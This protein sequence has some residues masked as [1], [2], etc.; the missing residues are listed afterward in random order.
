MSTGC[1]PAIASDGCDR[2]SACGKH[3]GGRDRAANRNRE[4][5]KDRRRMTLKRGG[6]RPVR[7]W[8]TWDHWHLAATLGPTADEVLDEWRMRAPAHGDGLDLAAPVHDS[9]SARRL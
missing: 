9:V 2:S 7:C 6:M 1:H 4:L 8:R 3:F 5:G